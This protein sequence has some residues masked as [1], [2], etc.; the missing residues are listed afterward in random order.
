VLQDFCKSCLYGIDA[1]FLAELIRSRELSLRTNNQNFVW[2]QVSLGDLIAVSN[3]GS[4]DGSV[5]ILSCLLS[6]NLH[7][8]CDL[9]LLNRNFIQFFL[10]KLLIL[11][12]F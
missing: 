9:M 7:K 11:A 8:I 4:L 1:Y 10:E 6:T 5:Q 3:D 2:N 12:L